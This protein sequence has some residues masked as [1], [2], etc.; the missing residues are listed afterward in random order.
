MFQNVCK[1]AFKCLRRHSAIFYRQLLLLTQLDPPLE[2]NYTEEFILA[3]IRKRFMV[4]ETHDSAELQFVTKVA[5]SSSS[6]YQH[7]LVDY[8]HDKG[9]TLNSL[10]DQISTMFGYYR[11]PSK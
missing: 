4:G 7:S 9:K 5:K 1:L 10:T 11:S 8:F 3:Q 6:S 2:D